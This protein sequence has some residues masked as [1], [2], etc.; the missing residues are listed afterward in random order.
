[1]TTPR[2]PDV[3]AWRVIAVDD[4]PDNL[5]VIGDLLELSG[6]TVLRVRSGQEALAA[7]DAFKPTL[8]L[9]DLLMP[10]MD[11]W[12]VFHEVRRHPGL[13]SLPVVALT[14]QAPSDASSQASTA[15]FDG[16]VVKPI[17]IPGIL[18]Y[19]AEVIAKKTPPAP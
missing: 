4:E 5:T 13:A 16:Y 11:G 1:M 12:E 6:A 19:L 17:P 8:M 9:L 15:D 7:L 18:M 3:S 14:A 10:N 2:M